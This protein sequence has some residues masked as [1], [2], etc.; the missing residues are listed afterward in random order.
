MWFV[1]Y[2]NSG[3]GLL[4]G[5][6]GPLW[7]I[8]GSSYCRNKAVVHKTITAIVTVLLSSAKVEDVF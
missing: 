4:V 3:P 1:V 8:T 5:V 7:S 6:C 2:S